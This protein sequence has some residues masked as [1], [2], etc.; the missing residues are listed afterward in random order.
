MRLSFLGNSY[1][2]S[3]PDIQVTKTEHPGMFLGNRFKLQQHS[4]ASRSHSATLKYR[5]VDYNA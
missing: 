1:E 3:T 2:A 5:G 4:A